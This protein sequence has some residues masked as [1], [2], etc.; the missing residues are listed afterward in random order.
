MMRLVA[1]LA[2]S[3][4]VMEVVSYFIYRSRSLSGLKKLYET[5]FRKNRAGLDDIR[6]FDLR[7]TEHP[8]YAMMPNPNF[9][10]SFNEKIHN[11]YGF[12]DD[13][14][15]SDID[16]EKDIVIYCAGESSTYCNFIEKN[17]DTWPAVLGIKL[18]QSSAG[19]KV[20]TINAA[21][22]AWT[23]YQSL[24]RFSAW[25]DVLKPKLVIIYHAKNDLGP[26]TSSRL[27]VSEI[28]PDY[29]NVMHSLRF[30]L[31][32]QK[33]PFLARYTYSGKV[34]Y[35]AY[36][37][38]RYV[39]VS[40]AIYNMTEASS[41]DRMTIGLKRMGQREMDFTLSRYKSFA[42]LCKDRD[43]PILFVTQKVVSPIYGPYVDRINE[44]VKAMENRRD[45]CYVYDF[46]GQI[47]DVKGIL[48][49]S[50]HFTV[51]GAA[52]FAE[53]IRDY[54]CGNIPLL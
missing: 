18:G 19:R 26:F 20:R 5:M 37:N 7:Y 16:C 36:V 13:R 6:T 40:W 27:S 30:D 9:R 17:K 22:S 47:K 28:Y 51:D 42:S 14:D 11:K 15:F 31:L 43:I 4:A 8:Y 45:G 10:N 53:C 48:Y 32:A 34:L 49:D 23:S 41:D 54:I 35:G 52:F 3:I 29:G 12:R 46:A 33:L 44:G 2:V 24:I 50:V 21:C 25:V 39:N 1:V 38:R